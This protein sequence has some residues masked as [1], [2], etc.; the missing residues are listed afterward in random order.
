E[1]NLKDYANSIRN[2]LD[3]GFVF[4]VNRNE[5]RLSMVASAGNKALENGINCGQVISKACSTANG[6][7]GGKPDLAQGG[8]SQT[9]PQTVIDEVKNILQSM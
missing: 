6:K 5:D 2:K 7:G 4:V 3:G 8:G 1:G 9:D